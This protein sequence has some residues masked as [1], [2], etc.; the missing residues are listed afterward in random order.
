MAN[1]VQQAGAA[2]TQK[3]LTADERRSSVSVNPQYG[4]WVP[5][6][7]PVLTPLA[8]EPSDVLNAAANEGRAASVPSR[9]GPGVGLGFVRPVQRLSVPRRPHVTVVGLGPAGTD[10]VGNAAAALLAEADPWTGLPAHGAPPGG[11]R[12]S[13]GLPAFDDL[14]EAAATFDE[15][16]DGIVEALV[17]AASAAAPERV[18]YAVPGSPLVA[19]RTVDL[20]R[21]DGRVEVTVVPALSFLDLAWAALGIDPLAEGVRL[22]DAGAFDASAA[23]RGAVPGGPV[24]VASPALRGQAGRVRRRRPGAAPAGAPAPSRAR[25]RGGGWRWTGGS[26]TARWSP[27]TSPRSTCPPSPPGAGRPPAREV[28]RLVALM[29]TLRERCPWDRP[30]PTRR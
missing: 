9:V 15:V 13:T 24:L 11:R 7:A 3:A 12:R 28:A 30:R 17:A 25:G 10:L 2:A 4:V 8:P 26:W 18:V 21:A 19:E 14:Y 5:V 22:V 6:N 20:L 29:D 27:T 23:A 16:Y 1:A